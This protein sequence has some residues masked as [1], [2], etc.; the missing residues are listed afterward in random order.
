[1]WCGVAAVC[2][3][4]CRDLHGIECHGA[5]M[6]IQQYLVGGELQ[7]NSVLAWTTHSSMRLMSTQSSNRSREHHPQSRGWYRTLDVLPSR[8]QTARLSVQ[9]LGPNFDLI[10]GKLPRL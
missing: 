9:T 2:P 3:A 5:V 10:R 4:V 8:L 1:V 7:V 6:G